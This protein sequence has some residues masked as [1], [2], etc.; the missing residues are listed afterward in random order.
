MPPRFLMLAL[1]GGLLVP[2]RSARAETHAIDGTI[3]V[4]EDHLALD[5]DLSGY[6]E[7]NLARQLEDGLPHTV[8]LRIVLVQNGMEDEEEHPLTSTERRCRLIYDLWGERYAVRVESPHQHFERWSDTARGAARVCAHLEALRL[9]P[10][11]RLDLRRTF[12]VRLEVHLD[13]PDTG[14]LGE[15]R[16]TFGDPTG[17]SSSPRPGATF[18]GAMARAF[19]RE[20]PPPE[21]PPEIFE[22]PVFGETLIREALDR[23]N[24]TG[25]EKENEPPDPSDLGARGKTETTKDATPPPAPAGASR[26]PPAGDSKRTNEDTRAPGSHE[27]S[28][29]TPG[30]KPD[31]GKGS[32]PTRGEDEEE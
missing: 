17:S 24:S 23:S 1:A 6:V 28:S 8:L 13:P 16:P 10:L 25:E 30:R 4:V 19:Y 12:Q 5:A 20:T 7:A 29:V 18:F 21:D 3:R 11:A 2:H 22:S 14:D 15:T 9:I 27:A 31:S 26:A 32:E